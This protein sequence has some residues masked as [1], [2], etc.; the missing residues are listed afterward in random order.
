MVELKTRRGGIF[1]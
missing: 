1:M